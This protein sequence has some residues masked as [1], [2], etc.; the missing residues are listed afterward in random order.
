MRS[1]RYFKITG[2]YICGSRAKFVA[3][4]ASRVIELAGNV[5]LIVAAAAL[6][7]EESRG[8]HARRDFPAHDPA[9][10]HRLTLRLH[11]AEAMA[12][13]ILERQ[14]AVAIGA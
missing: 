11:D 10:G 13:N 6:M 1:P 8:S 12:R 9:W 2:K 3:G 4:I 14:S 7:R 5:A